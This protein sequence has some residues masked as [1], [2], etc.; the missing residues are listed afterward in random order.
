MPVAL[1]I[2]CSTGGGHTTAKTNVANKLTEM[3]HTLI[4]FDIADFFFPVQ[5]IVSSSWDAG[6]RHDWR[7][8]H[9]LDS[10]LTF[11]EFM[12]ELFLSKR[13]T[14]ALT[15][16]IQKN[17]ISIIYDMQP[18]MTNLIVKIFST[19]CPQGEY[20]KIFT[21]LPYP[22]N[23]AYLGSL[24]RTKHRD[25]INLYVHAPDTVTSPTTKNFW[26][27]YAG[28]SDT[29]LKQTFAL[30]VHALYF[31]ASYRVKAIPLDCPL[32]QFCENSLRAT[33]SG[34]T[35]AS[36]TQITT[37]MLGSQGL[38]ATLDYAKQFLMQAKNTEQPALFFVACAKNTKLYD[39]VIDYANT[40]NLP[41]AQVLPLPQIS[42]DILASIMWQSDRH[43]I[44]P[45]GLSCLEQLA[46]RQDAINAQKPLWLHSGM[47]KITHQHLTKR[48]LL[49]GC[50]GHERANAEHMLASTPSLMVIPSTVQ[51]F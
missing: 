15:E 13:L 32:T 42:Q 7:I 49:K 3:G 16:I 41:H 48:D 4:E 36:G 22:G 46:L 30:P 38:N 31:D 25:N 47:N 8:V 40:H 1:I 28:I 24:K 26:K 14:A 29:Q 39:D 23:R 43:I 50:F 27:N 44:R 18:T 17:N 9:D 20:H 37:L 10:M 2:S 21:D 11:Y 51:F 45:S 5:D 33:E 12:Y 6:V 34:Y 19:I 35:I